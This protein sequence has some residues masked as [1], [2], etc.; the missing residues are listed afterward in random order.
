[1]R[2]LPSL[3][4]LAPRAL[5]VAAAVACGAVPDD[6][7]ARIVPAQGVIEG[8]I[9]YQGPRPCSSQGHIVGNAILLV[10]DRR[11]PPPPAGLANV[12]AN[13]ADVTGD[14]LFASE[15]RYTGDAVYCPADHGFTDPVTVSAPFTVSPLAG[16]SYEI[17]AFFDTTGDFLPTFKFRDLPEQGDVGGGDIDTADALRAINAG[18]P[19]YVPQFVPVD[20]G[21][22][23]TSPAPISLGGAIPVYDIPASGYVAQDVTVSIG[24]V[25]PSTRPYFYAGGVTVALSPDDSMLT[26]TVVQESDIAP[27]STSG[28]LGTVETDPDYTPILTI[29]QD[30]QAYAPPGLSQSGA[31]LFEQPLPHLELVFGVPDSAGAPAPGAA[32]NSVP[33]NELPCATGVACPESLDP[34]PIDP[35]HFQLQESAPEGSFLVWQNAAFDAATGTWRP[36]QIA[37]GNQVPML[38]PV[39][40]LS[41]LI[42]DDEVGGQPDP[43]HSNDPASLTAQG[44]AGQPVV[45]MQGITFLESAQ[46]ALDAQADTLFNT[47][48]AGPALAGTLFDPTTGLP[49]VFQQDHLMVAL[50]PSVICFDHLFDDP[51]WPDQR[52]TLVTP[53]S[54]G[55]VADAPPSSSKLGPIVPPDLLNNGDPT[56]F[57]VDNL[58]GAVKYGCLPR[59]RYAINVVYP[60]G[61]A[62]TVPNETGACSGSEGATDFAH[63]T[64]TL[65]PRPVLYSQGNRAVVEVVGATNP[66]NCQAQTPSPAAGPP[67]QTAIAFG[68]PAPGV[69]AVC[70]PAQ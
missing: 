16:G 5:F 65:E 3:S 56:R 67:D 53:F 33:A 11:N 68:G 1:M 14:A 41:K 34:G 42:D 20:V 50:R 60:D 15:P 54:Q 4:R 49:T 31:N 10:F 62:W 43:H 2:A 66:A 7:G 39:V 55:E 59:G 61:Q 22:P 40:I 44:G 28:I 63:L 58:V 17:Q 13:F 18:N 36:L 9:V 69:P 35:F 48:A 26:P 23:E 30:L 45:I 29:P 25:I 64:C 12:P 37:E 70:L 46:T 27:P 8:T 52:G 24:A 19:N 47:A 21:I 57:Q 51:P 38:W 32:P 6:P